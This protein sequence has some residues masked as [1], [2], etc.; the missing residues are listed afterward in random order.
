MG[1]FYVI[2]SGT[3]QMTMDVIEKDDPRYFTATSEGSYDRHTYRIHLVNGDHVDLDNYEEVQMT[4]FRNP[5]R[6]LSHVE[7]LDTQKKPKGF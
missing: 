1:F 6:F 2:I 7:V 3:T 4:W 5:S